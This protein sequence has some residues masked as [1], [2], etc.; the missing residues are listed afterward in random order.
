MMLDRDLPSYTPI[1]RRASGSRRGLVDPRVLLERP[2]LLLPPSW[3]DASLDIVLTTIRAA[4][5]AAGE[6]SGSGCTGTC[7]NC[8]CGLS[9]QADL[10][11]TVVP[12]SPVAMVD[13]NDALQAEKAEP[14][15]SIAEKMVWTLLTLLL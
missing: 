14:E 4:H 3:P 1:K 13:S 6:G 5:N 15:V 11:V 10:R 2:P 9:K 12:K 7:A 8:K